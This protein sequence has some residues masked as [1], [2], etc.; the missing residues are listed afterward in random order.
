V[1]ADKP[2]LDQR[3]DFDPEGIYASIKLAAQPSR[4]SQIQGRSVVSPPPAG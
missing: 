3:F 1:T 4:V 2:I